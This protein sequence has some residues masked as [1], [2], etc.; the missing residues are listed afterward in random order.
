MKNSK[1]QIQNSRLLFCILHFAFCIVYANAQSTNQSYPTAVTSNEISGRIAARDIGDARLTNYFYVFGGSQG[2]VFINVQATNFN[3]DIDIFTVGNLKP[4]TKITIYASDTT[5]ET[6]RVVYLRQPAKLILRV[7]GRTP[8]DDAATFRIKFAGSFEPVQAAT[9]ENA[10]PETPEVKSENQT[11]VRVNSVG[12]I[13]EVKPKP[14][15]PPKEIVAKKEVNPKNKK[16]TAATGNKKGAKRNETATDESQPSKTDVNRDAAEKREEETVTEKSESET[17]KKPAPVVIVTDNSV[18]QDAPKTDAEVSSEEAKEKSAE[19][20]TGTPGKSSSKN[21][22][23]TSAKS[24]PATKSKK[25]KE[26]NPLE[27]VHLIILLKDGTRIER[28]MSE[29]TKVSVDRGVLTVISNDGTIRRY[30]ILDV[31]KMTIE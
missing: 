28:A 1:L 3:G 23:E 9:A 19:K 14:L 20:T 15:P 7:E 11:D 24:K 21:N 29:V 5:S 10:A 6:G 25:A 13:L 27:N 26:P 18:K 16:S 8:N 17:E 12:T 30:P 2:D 31:A 4:L 22:T